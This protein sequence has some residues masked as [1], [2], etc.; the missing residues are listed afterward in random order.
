MELREDASL[1]EDLVDAFCQIAEIDRNDAFYSLAQCDK[2]KEFDRVRYRDLKIRE[3][4]ATRKLWHALDL[5]ATIR[6]G[7]VITKT[8]GSKVEDV[9]SQPI[10]L[11][12]V[13]DERGDGHELPMRPSLARKRKRLGNCASERFH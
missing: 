8:T 11:D 5:V 7:M 9:E 2:A 1:Y 3:R 6:E 10:T 12:T 13:H 4:F